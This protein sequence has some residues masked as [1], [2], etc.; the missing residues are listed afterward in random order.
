MKKLMISLVALALL[1]G[2][3]SSCAG[4]NASKHTTYYNE[5]SKRMDAGV[6]VS[7]DYHISGNISKIHNPSMVN[8]IFTQS[9]STSVKGSIPEKLLPYLK[10]ELSGGVLDISVKEDKL[11]KHFRG[12]K[13]R[14]ENY[15]TLYVTAKS[16]EKLN[17]EGTGD[18]K[19]KNGFSVSLKG[20]VVNSY[21]TGDFSI[22]GKLDAA[23]GKVRFNL[24]GTGDLALNNVDAQSN[25]FYVG[26]MGTG[27]ANINTLVCGELKAE[28]SG[29]SDVNLK[30]FTGDKLNAI[31]CGTGDFNCNKINVNSCRASVTGTGDMRL[32]GNSVT[33]YLNVSGT[34]DIHAS[35]LMAVDGEAI[36]SGSGSI[37]CKVRNLDKR[38]SGSGDV[39]N[40]I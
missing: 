30:S 2:A 1:A 37:D 3:V 32:S 4:V 12:F 16:L 6:C 31:V 21:G 24:Y 29:T 26:V 13:Y 8:I 23:R 15:P 33:V 5:N 38:V 22:G 14:E 27:N 7:K 40:R 18:F 17:M 9:A 20:L 35:E 25:I 34:G 11:P 36:V 10:V 39:K 19:I 28:V